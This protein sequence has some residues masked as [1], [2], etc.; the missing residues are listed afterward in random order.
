MIDKKSNM[1][2]MSELTEE[3]LK[4]IYMP[5]ID[6]YELEE[7]YSEADKIEQDNGGSPP[8]MRYRYEVGRLSRMSM[9][10]AEKQ[11]PFVITTLMNNLHNDTFEKYANKVLNDRLN[12]F[13]KEFEV[14][15]EMVLNKLDDKL[16]ELMDE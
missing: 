6:Y 15:I 13:K 1:V 10:S 5:M 4:C 12:G 9:R 8:F 2:C 14:R 16:K 3:M 11:L 7:M